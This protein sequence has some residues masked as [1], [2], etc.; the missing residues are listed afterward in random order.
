MGQCVGVVGSVLS[1][2]GVALFQQIKQIQIFVFAICL[3]GFSPS[4]GSRAPTHTAMHGLK[5]LSALCPP[6][7]VQ[8]VWVEHPPLEYTHD[9][10]VH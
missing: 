8:I 6:T 1:P 3:N 9:T 4:F 5:G 7:R 10:A 2:W